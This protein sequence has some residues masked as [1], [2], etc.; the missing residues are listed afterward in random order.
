MSFE[1]SVQVNEGAQEFS[2]VTQYIEQVQ[3]H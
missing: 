1:C 3:T 2:H